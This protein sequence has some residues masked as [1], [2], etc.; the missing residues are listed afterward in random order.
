MHN[1]YVEFGDRL[2]VLYRKL[3]DNQKINAEV[4]KQYWHC[5]TVLRK[6]GI[7]YFCNEI[8]TIEFKEI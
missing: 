1:E 6:D 2:F 4:L 3:K 8:Q 7:F 5:D